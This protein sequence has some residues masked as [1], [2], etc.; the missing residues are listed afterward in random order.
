MQCEIF[1][2]CDAA[3]VTAG[4]MSLLGSFDSLGARSFPARHHQC[5]VAC[6]LR[7]DEADSGEHELVIRIIDPDGNDVLEPSRTAFHKTIGEDRTSVHLHIWQI[8]GFRLPKHGEF[9]ID[10]ILDGTVLCRQPL[11]VRLIE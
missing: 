2:L 10:L 3:T 1:T 6:K 9:Y 5:A 4:K 11:H 8:N 7:L